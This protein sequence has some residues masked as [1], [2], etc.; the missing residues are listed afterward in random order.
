MDIQLYKD[1]I[2]Y[3][4]DGDTP[5]VVSS[6]VPTWYKL[7]AIIVLPGGGYSIHAEHEAEPIARFYNNKG[8]HTFI[9]KYRLL[10]N[11]YPAALCDLQ[12]LIKYLRAHCES[13]KIDPNKIFVIGFSAGGH[14]AALSSVSE[15]VSPIDFSGK[16]FSHKPS[17]VILG[18]PVINIEHSC[19]K[20]LCAY[21]EDYYDKLSVYKLIDSSTPQM[22]IWHTSDDNVADVSHSLKLASALRNNNV[23]YEM[24]IFPSGEHGLGL[25][26]LERGISKWPQLSVEWILSNF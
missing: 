2:P 17:G 18:Y 16:T 12:T 21:N 13:L 9:L 14:L 4:I 6:L 24:H 7:P 25:A 15:D 22:F 11:L 3:S 26:Q 5:S 19:V 8:F 10:P 20:E 23:R 1:D